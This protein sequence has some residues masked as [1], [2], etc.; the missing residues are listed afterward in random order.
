MSDDLIPGTP[1]RSVHLAPVL[2][3]AAMRA[4][5]AYTIEVLGIPGFTLMETAGREAAR[6]AA[7]SLSPGSRILVIAGKGN[8]GGDG[9]VV[10]RWL[11]DEGYPVDVWMTAPAE[12]LAPD[13]AMNWAILERLETS[14]LEV[15]PAGSWSA[16]EIAS[17]RG[18]LIV[19]ALFGTGLESALRAP[20]DVVVRA[21]N[22]HAAP[23]WAL[24]VPSGLSAT[25]GEAFDPCVN[26]SVTVTM[27]A[28]KS[29]LLLGD[30]PDVSGSVQ[31]VDIGIPKGALSGNA[32]EA[33]SGFLSGDT[34]V[35]GLLRAR[36]RSDHKYTT[37]PTLIVGGSDAFPG[38]P[39]LA[40]RAAARIGSGYVIAAGPASIR[41]ILQEQLD[42]IP[43]ASWSTDTHAQAAIESLIDDLGDR[44]T[45]ARALVIGPGLGRSE[46]VASQIWVLLSAFDG[47][48][49]LDADA[50]FA[51]AADRDRVAHASNGHW[52]L[53]PHA[54]ELARLDP[55]AP[56][57]ANLVTRVQRVAKAWNCVILSKGQPS[58]TSHPDGRT[59]IN[60]TGHP[61]AA[62]A[63]TGDVLAGIVAGLLAQGVEPL[64]AAA[65]AI[66]IGGTAAGRFVERGAAQSLVASDLIEALPEV[67]RHLS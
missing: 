60:A 8:N 67:L 31:V 13:A 54:G 34:W 41:S 6:L 49:V 39:A 63:G 10:A 27:G 38:A 56:E 2:S 53:T 21:M 42:A 15:R 37:G 48:V 62:T 22:E 1:A 19:D 14:R 43:V 33:G 64:E 11:A 66:H 57:D 7:A 3:A 50:L 46:Q 26:A 65:A 59:I 45:K 9:L 23:V 24:D 30:G 61:A 16:D 17:W 12:Q 44:W 47:P 29:G 36:T 18:D 5:D 32:M 25:T 55:D 40:A 35:S 58:I 52:V 28:L 20:F 51:V 4:A